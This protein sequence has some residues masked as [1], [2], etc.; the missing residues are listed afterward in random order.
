MYIYIY[1][2]QIQIYTLYNY[3]YYIYFMSTFIYSW[4]DVLRD[5]INSIN[6]DVDVDVSKLH[7]NLQLS[8]LE[9]PLNGIWETLS[10]P[11]C[12]IITPAPQ[13]LVKPIFN[14]F[15]PSLQTYPQ[16]QILFSPMVTWIHGDQEGYVCSLHHFHHQDF[17]F[18]LMYQWNVQLCRLS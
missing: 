9:G 14:C 1:I 4:W 8:V 16:H 10:T 12:C 3:I 15:F 17:S 11:S 7:K 13:L 6:V 5:F 2:L 18:V